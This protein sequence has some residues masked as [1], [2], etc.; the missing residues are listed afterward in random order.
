MLKPGHHWGRQKLPVKLK[1]ETTVMQDAAET[2][3]WANHIGLRAGRQR[4][5][6]N[7]GSIY[8]HVGKGKPQSPPRY[9]GLITVTD[10]V[11]PVCFP[12]L[13]HKEDSA[14]VL[15]AGRAGYSE[16]AVTIADLRKS[17]GY[18]THTLS[19]SC[20]LNYSPH[21]LFRTTKMNKGKVR[22]KFHKVGHLVQLTAERFGCGGFSPM[23]FS[24]RPKHLHF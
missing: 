5:H 19:H 9:K 23:C 13:C 20:H 2:L 8:V 12:Q 4:R 24:V 15:P 7:I 17:P 10:P 16:V 1:D 14:S 21:W 6:T 3:H 18:W 11:Q 22:Q